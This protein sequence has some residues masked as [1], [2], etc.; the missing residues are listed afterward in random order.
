VA[1]LEVT[2][3]AKRSLAGTG[4]HDAS[5]ILGIGSQARPQGEQVL[6]HLRIDRVQHLGPVQRDDQHVRTVVRG[7]QGVQARKIHVASGSGCG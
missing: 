2:A 6:P 3:G 7:L 4:Q 5:D 1:L